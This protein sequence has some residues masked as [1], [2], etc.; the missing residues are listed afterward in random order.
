[1]TVSVKMC[2]LSSERLRKDNGTHVTFIDAVQHGVFE[3]TAEALQELTLAKRKSYIAQITILDAKSNRGTS[4]QNPTNHDTNEES[5][6][7]SK[8]VHIKSEHRLLG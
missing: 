2:Y 1:M 8:A 5:E 4:A 7:H 3:S 6:D